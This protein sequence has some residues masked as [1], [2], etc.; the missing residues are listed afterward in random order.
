MNLLCAAGP[1]GLM[2]ELVTALR[3]PL[4]AWFTQQRY[5]R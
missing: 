1:T 3:A 5:T 4:G 2:H